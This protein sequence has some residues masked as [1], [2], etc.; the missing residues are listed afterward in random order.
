MKCQLNQANVKNSSFVFECL[1]VLRLITYLQNIYYFIQNVL[2]KCKKT[3][4]S[5]I[6]E[7]ESNPTYPIQ[8]K[9]FVSEVQHKKFNL[10]INW[11]LTF[12]LENNFLLKVQNKVN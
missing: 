1:S 6:F 9:M 7:E 11:S 8:S 5:L 4:K 3:T 2:K 10:V 12:T